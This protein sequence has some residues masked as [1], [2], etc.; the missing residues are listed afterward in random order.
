MIT[1]TISERRQRGTFARRT[2]EKRSSC[3]L[4][5]APNREGKRPRPLRKDKKKKKKGKKTV[6]QG[7]CK[8]RRSKRERGKRARVVKSEP[9]KGVKKINAAKGGRRLIANKIRGWRVGNRSY[10]VYKK[11]KENNT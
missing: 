6:L 9:D 2:R 5:S 7:V 3:H 11:G 10:S 4:N 1:F 8:K